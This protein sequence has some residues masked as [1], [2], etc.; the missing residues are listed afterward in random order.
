VARI[1]IEETWWTD[2]RRA[3]LARHFSGDYAKADGLVVAMWRV[4]QEFW[5]KDRLRIPK[6]IFETLE[7]WELLVDCKLAILEQSEVYVRGS[8]QRLNWSF[9][10]RNKLNNS[11][12]G[13][14]S[15]KAREQKYGTSRP[16]I[17]HERKVEKQVI[18][19]RSVEF[20]TQGSDQESSTYHEQNTNGP[21]TP[22]EQRSNETN[23]SCSSSCSKK[24]ET[25]LS[26]AEPS[27]ERGIL[28][29]SKKEP[30][31]IM[32]V[33]NQNCS[34]LQKVKELNIKREKLCKAYWLKNSDPAVWAKQIKDF[35]A[36][37]HNQGEPGKWK[38]TFDF[39]MRPDIQTRVF[40]GYYKPKAAS[41]ASA[42]FMRAAALEAGL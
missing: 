25:T 29:T 30:H 23:R 15:A 34:P 18:S 10:H 37:K 27:T 12:A 20:T 40:E 21:R 13:R 31:P 1:N 4:A 19:E 16:N 26:T 8:S 28:N 36:H 33:W 35:A 3:K 42:A 24:E 2:P 22:F 6:E 14:A 32:L 5:S 11:K 41:N 38:A 9:E 39:F 7:S 17:T